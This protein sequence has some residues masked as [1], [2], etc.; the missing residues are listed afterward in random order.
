MESRMS[1]PSIPPEP[2]RGNRMIV[3]LQVGGF[4]FALANVICVAILAWTYIHVK[5]EPRT[6][7]VKGSARK[8]IQSDLIS[9]SGTMVA[10]DKDLIAAYD[11]LKGDADRVA[12][13]LKT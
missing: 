4:F 3:S 9:W 12:A 7:E 10:R 6:L 8:A 2:G 11:K 5:L 13:F 1:S